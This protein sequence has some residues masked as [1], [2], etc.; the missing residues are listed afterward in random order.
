MTSKEVRSVPGES[1]ESKFSLPVE[2][3]SR[4]ALAHG[5]LE[6]TGR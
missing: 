3:I 6:E 5:S 4:R 2:F 1:A